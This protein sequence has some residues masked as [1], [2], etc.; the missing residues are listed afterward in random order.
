MPGGSLPHGQ[1]VCVL[2]ELSRMNVHGGDAP[3][4]IEQNKSVLLD[5]NS[6]IVEYFVVESARGQDLNGHVVQ[7][8]E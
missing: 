1:D 3:I 8:E 4:D 5:M 6:V 7:S 2:C